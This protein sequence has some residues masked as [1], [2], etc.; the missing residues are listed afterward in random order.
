MVFLFHK[1]G[2]FPLT[3]CFSGKPRG[4]PPILSPKAPNA[5]GTP[6]NRIRTK[7]NYKPDPLKIS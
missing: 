1:Q 4:G 2:A 5:P 6:P 7:I 3:K